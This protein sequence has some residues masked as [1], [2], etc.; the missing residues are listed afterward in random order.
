MRKMKSQNIWIR[1][2][3]G[4]CTRTRQVSSQPCHDTTHHSSCTFSRIKVV[5][6]TINAQK[7]T[8]Y[9]IACQFKKKKTENKY[10]P[11]EVMCSCNITYALWSLGGLLLGLHVFF[12]GL[13]FLGYVGD[14]QNK[15]RSSINTDQWVPGS[16]T[17]SKHPCKTQLI[18]QA[19]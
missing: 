8:N 12:E 18:P 10:L 9:L 11:S 6:G 7:T 16:G 14:L 2:K 4:N 5:P 3:R 15:N 1:L 17:L 19:R 13:D